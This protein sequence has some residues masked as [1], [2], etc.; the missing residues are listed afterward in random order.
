MTTP[1][2]TNVS[3][4]KMDLSIFAGVQPTVGKQAVRLGFDPLGGEAVTGIYRL[5]QYVAAMFLTEIGSDP[6]D[7]EYGTEFITAARSGILRS[8]PDVSLY[9]NLAASSIMRYFKGTQDMAALR[10][11]EVLRDLVLESFSLEK[12]GP[13]GD[14]GYPL[15]KLK[16]RVYSYSDDLEIPVAVRVV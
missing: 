1:F 15:L 8:D 16:V 9:F 12:N 5:S 4:R 13:A 14:P 7:P 10:P 3:G 2:T 6:F 11:D